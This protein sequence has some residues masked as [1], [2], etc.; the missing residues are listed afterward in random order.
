V[1]LANGS[2]A[3]V[4][5]PLQ[6]L[7]LIPN[8]KIPTA[9]GDDVYLTFWGSSDVNHVETHELL[10]WSF[11]SSGISEPSTVLS[12]QTQFYSTKATTWAGVTTGLL[13]ALFILWSIFRFA[14]PS[15]F[16]YYSKLKYT[17]GPHV[18]LYAEL[19]KATQNFDE[20]NILGTGGSGSVYNAVKQINFSKSKQAE[21]LFHAEVSS[22][23]QIRHRNVVQLHGCQEKGRLLLVYE[24]MPNGC[25]NEWLHKSDGHFQH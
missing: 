8:Y 2:S 20:K 17:E 7:L 24:Y 19:R 6:P 23:G 3:R 21:A 12:S 16:Q 10:S 9:L 15:R 4:K 13:A 22:L 18:F 14:R 25:L 5:K 1:W 11:F